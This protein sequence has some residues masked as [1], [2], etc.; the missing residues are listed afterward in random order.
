ML[1][2]SVTISLGELEESKAPL[3]ESKELEEFSKLSDH[4]GTFTQDEK[5]IDNTADAKKQKK[6]L[7]V[8]IS[9]S[10]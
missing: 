5:I 10:F 6:R 4:A 7:P 8:F 1:N 3:E 9:I 2:S